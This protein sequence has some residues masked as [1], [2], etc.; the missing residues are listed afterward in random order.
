MEM[1]LYID[2]DALA[3]ALVNGLRARGFEI[4]TVLEAGMKGRDDPAQLAYAIQ[5]GRVV[6]T[7]NVG[8]FCRLHT[9]YLVQGKTHTGIIVVPRQKYSIGE[10]IRKLASFISSSSAEEMENKLHFL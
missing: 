7:F 2:E 6:Y 3:R 5:Q 8:H 1:R 10:Q 4:L 9:E